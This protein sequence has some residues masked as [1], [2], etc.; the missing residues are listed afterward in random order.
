VHLLGNMVFLLAFGPYVE[1]VF[2]RLLFVVLY[3][4][5]G[6]VGSQTGGA[7]YVFCYGASGAISGVMG[8]YLVR[9]RNRPLALLNVPSVWFPVLRVE[10]SV[11]ASAFLLFEL[12]KDLRGAW[13]GIPGVGWGAHIGGFAFGVLFAGLLGLTR[14]EKNV[15]DPGIEA[16][17][18]FREHPA[19][20]RSFALRTKGLA[21]AAHHTVEAALVGQPW[22][23][24]LLREAYDAAVAAGALGRAGTHATRLVGQLG[25]R[26]DSDDAR[27]TRLFIQ[28]AREALGAALPARFHFAAGD[29][30]ERQGQTAQAL[31]LYEGLAGHPEAAVARRAAARQARLRARTDLVWQQC[32]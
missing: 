2:G 20:E 28:E 5:A 19:V 18:T 25:A 8:A 22:N 11:P 31:L 9:F 23:V 21:E 17:L 26:S 27:E 1:D 6:M 14:I 12:A 16:R 4:G 10:V 7:G 15:I 24:A 29:S 3:L 32:A 30:L 13:L